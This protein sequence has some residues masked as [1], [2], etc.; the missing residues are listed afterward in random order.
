MRSWDFFDTLLGRACGEPWRVFDLMGGPEFRAVRQEAEQK[1]DRTFEGIYR[2]MQE[3][4]GWSASRVNELRQ[5]EWDWERR[6]AFPIM[7]NVAQVKPG[8][9]IVT[10]TYFNADQIRA[11]ADVIKLPPLEIIASY[12]G[13][14]HGAV[15][16]ALR[17][18]GRKITQH[19]GDNAHADFAQAKRHGVVATLYSDGNPSGIEKIL[20]DE[21]LWDVAALARAVRLQNPYRDRDPRRLVWNKHAKYN[22]P[23]LLLCAARLHAYVQEHRYKHV[24]FLSRDTYLMRRVFQALYPEITAE[25]FYASRQTYTAPSESFLQ[26]ARQA[27]EKPRSVFFDLQGTGT[28]VKKFEDAT[29]IKLDYVYCATPR[30]LPR[31]VPALYLIAA[32]GTA[33]E[34][35]N[36]DVQGRV[37]DVVGGVPVRAELEYDLNTVKVGHEVVDCLLRHIYRPPAVPSEKLMH[38]VFTQMQ[39]HVPRALCKQHQ[40]HHP[41]IELA[42]KS[43]ARRDATR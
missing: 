3:M 41:V 26:Y 11:L 24:W 34:V 7:D 10:D 19:T 38:L 20:T 37:I 16:R 36:Y 29:G 39:Q 32:D 18:E 15:W 13:K 25:M 12:G 27:A 1:S 6:L 31:F 2:T 8:E 28:S 33:M 14:H 4:T 42:R 43:E 9:L 40:V 23:F 35:F 17:R 5:Q 21:N 30:R 22:V